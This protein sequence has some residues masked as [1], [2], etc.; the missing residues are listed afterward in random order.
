M[1]D[2]QMELGFGNAT[3]R[4]AVNRRQR[5]VSRAN[6]WFARM[7]EVVDRAFDWQPAPPARPEQIWFADRRQ[8]PVP[9]PLAAETQICE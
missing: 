2:G 3:G 9:A 4:Q 8:S 7:R 5:R 1:I 6:W